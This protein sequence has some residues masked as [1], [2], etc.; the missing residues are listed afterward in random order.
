M[1][2]N[3]IYRRQIIIQNNFITSTVVI[4]EHGITKK[5]IKERLYN[6]LIKLS[7]V[8]GIEKKPLN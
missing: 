7:G 8:Y 2:Y 3:S 1:I 5:A 4:P 6:R